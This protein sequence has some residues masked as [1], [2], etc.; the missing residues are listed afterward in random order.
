[1]TLFLIYI[2]GTLFTFYYETEDIFLNK[3]TTPLQ[4]TLVFALC[5]PA[6]IIFGAI[7]MWKEI[8][9]NREDKK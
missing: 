5:W 1:M 8:I 6:S 4:S 2:I 7:I 9:K 3:L